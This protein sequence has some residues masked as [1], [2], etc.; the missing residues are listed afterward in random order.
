MR[1]SIVGSFFFVVGVIN[2]PTGKLMRGI[3][4]GYRVGCVYTVVCWVNEIAATA[5]I[6]LLL[7]ARKCSQRVGSFK[8]KSTRGHHWSL[9]R[10]FRL[11]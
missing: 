10:P 1:D 5:E 11:R 3:F 9:V 7:F 8:S 2:R 4:D 6:P